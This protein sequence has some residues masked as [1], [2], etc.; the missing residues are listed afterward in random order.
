[1]VYPGNGQSHAGLQHAGNM[2]DQVNE[3]RPPAVWVVLPVRCLMPIHL[4]APRC[5]YIPAALRVFILWCSACHNPSA[6]WEYGFC[7][8]QLGFQLIGHNVRLR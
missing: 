6:A 7:Q 5:F 2:P 4:W 1:M 8:S 3:K